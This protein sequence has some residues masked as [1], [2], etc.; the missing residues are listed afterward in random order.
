MD[1]GNTK[2]YYVLEST[3]KGNFLLKTNWRK[4]LGSGKTPKMERIEGLTVRNFNNDG[5]RQF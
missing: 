1:T 5:E 3:L 4:D 2:D